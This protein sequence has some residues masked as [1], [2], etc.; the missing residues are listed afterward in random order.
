MLDLSTVGPAARCT[1]LLADYGALGRQGRPGALRRRGADRAAVLRLQRPPGHAP[2]AGRS[3]GST[4]GARPSWPWRPRPTWWSRASGPAWSTGWASATRVSA[5]NPGIVYCSTTGYGQD[6]P[7]VQWAGHDI[8]YLAVGGFLGMS[9]PGADGAPPL[10]GATIA[11]AAA[12]GMQAALGHHRR[13]GRPGSDGTRGAISTCRWPRACSGS[14]RSPSTSSW[15]WAATSLP[16]H[17]VL[18]G[19]YACYGDLRRIRRQ[20]AGRRRHRGQ[21]LRQPVQAPGMPR[22]GHL[23]ATTTAAQ[24]A[25]GRPSPAAFA[26]RT[27]DEWVDRLAGCRHLRRAR[28][29][30][31]RG[32]R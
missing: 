30:G 13:A 3:Q 15:R 10:P 25:S 7:R 31:R 26:T 1:R 20:V 16:G 9:T 4:T 27:R 21:V 2:G 18:S 14:C 24:P 32:G 28:A 19:R 8:D 12:G 17:D 5:R 23:P 11:D 22:A 29:R 6:G